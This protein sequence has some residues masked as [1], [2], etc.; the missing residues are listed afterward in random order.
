MRGNEEGRG[1]AQHDS[2]ESR[3]RN[4]H[5]RH[6]MAIYGDGLIQDLRI[7]VEPTHPKRVSEDYDWR[8]S[9]CA[10]VFRSERPT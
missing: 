8:N 2:A 3:D 7:G 1:I 10:I 4:S 5:H 6:R 9:G